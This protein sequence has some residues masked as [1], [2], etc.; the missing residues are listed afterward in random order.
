MNSGIFLCIIFTIIAILARTVTTKA[1]TYSKIAEIPEALL[2]LPLPIIIESL[3]KLKKSLIWD[4][5]DLKLESML[6][7]Q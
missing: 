3:K 6:I 2:T 1:F 7:P 4:K 5:I